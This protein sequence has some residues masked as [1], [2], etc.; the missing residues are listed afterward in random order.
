M[1]PPAFF[2]WNSSS[3]IYYGQQ[4][5]FSYSEEQ[6][7]RTKFVNSKRN[8]VLAFGFSEAASY[9]HMREKGGE[10]STE[11]W[12]GS[13]LDISSVVPCGPALSRES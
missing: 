9:S 3:S 7:G 4:S 10:Q 12:Q 11:I 8:S 6:C 13:Q 5:F 1:L 2:R